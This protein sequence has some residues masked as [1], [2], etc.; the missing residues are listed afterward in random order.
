M[1]KIYCFDIDETLCTSPNLNYENSQPYI[2]RISVVNKLFDEGHTIKLFTARG[3]KTGIDWSKITK[4]QLKLWGLKYHELHFGKPHADYYIDDK[5]IDI[6]GW[7][8]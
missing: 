1:K 8:N 7:F 6:L 5:A 2:D 4:N 3:S